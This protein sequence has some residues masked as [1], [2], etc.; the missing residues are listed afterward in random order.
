MNTLPHLSCNISMVRVDPIGNKAK[1]DGA[2]L[3]TTRTTG[4]SSV[5]TEM[6]V[7]IHVTMRI[8]QITKEQKNEEDLNYRAS[9]EKEGGREVLEG[10]QAE[11]DFTLNIWKIGR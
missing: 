11:R 10:G 7:S 1:L 3:A 5:L 8:M 4:T 9:D 2:E 6:R